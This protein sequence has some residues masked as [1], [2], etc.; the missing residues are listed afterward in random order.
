MDTDNADKFSD[1][2]LKW[3]MDD[4]LVLLSVDGRQAV[5]LHRQVCD[6]QYGD[7]TVIDHMSGVRCN[8]LRSDLDITDAA[9]NA[10]NRTVIRSATGILGV[11]YGREKKVYVA[12][13]TAEYI[14][15]NEEYS[16]VE[17]AAYAR[18]ELGKELFPNSYK[19]LHTPKPVNF[20][21]CKWNAAK[22]AQLAELRRARKHVNTC[23]EDDD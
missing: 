11:T 5:S 21:R 16:T 14:R 23:N 22:Y 4:Y 15:F 18:N 7:N 20:I 3:D 10:R 9:C 12:R 6:R 2:T 1:I 17:E 19:D 13:M 8:A